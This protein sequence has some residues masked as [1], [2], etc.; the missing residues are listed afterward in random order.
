M[1]MSECVGGMTTCAMSSVPLSL[2]LTFGLALPVAVGCDAA[3][4]ADQAEVAPVGLTTAQ[5]YGI[6][7]PTFNLH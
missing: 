7:A 4:I 6:L 3:F 5:R 1:Y 2:R